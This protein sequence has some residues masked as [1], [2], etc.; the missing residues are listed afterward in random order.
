MKKTLLLAITSLC[1]GLTACSKMPSECEKS[2]KHIEELAKQ[3]G[4]P[5][6]AIK[7]QKKQFEEQIKNMPKDQAIQSC[8]AQSSILGMVK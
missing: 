5:D 7:A 3:S 6:D 2:W 1:I 4:I 8:N